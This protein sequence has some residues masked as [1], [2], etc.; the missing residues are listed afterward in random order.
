MNSYTYKGGL[1]GTMDKIIL[2]IE[3]SDVTPL[4]I[5]FES[6]DNNIWRATLYYRYM[7]DVRPEP[8]EYPAEVVKE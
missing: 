3:A 5:I 1:K 2:F 8:I 6:L 4:D 7:R